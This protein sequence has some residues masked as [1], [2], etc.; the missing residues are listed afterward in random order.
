[1]FRKGL[2]WCAVVLLLVW[3]AGFLL[4]PYVAKPLIVRAL[5]DALQRPVSIRAI[6]FNPIKLVARIE[7][8][9]LGEAAGAEGNF[10]SVEQLS[11][12]LQARSLWERATVID[13]LIITGPQFK[14]VRNQDGSFNFAD[15]LALL[16]KPSSSPPARFVLHNIQLRAGHVALDD[17]LVEARHTVSDIHFSLPFLSNLPGAAQT[18]VEPVL[19]A[20]LN[21]A[22]ISVKAQTTPFHPTR[23]TRAQI[24]AKDVDVPAY[25]RYLPA[26]LNAELASGR[27][28]A[29]LAVSFKQSPEQA[30][31]VG[32]SGVAALHGVS[33]RA[34][35]KTPILSSPHLSL[36]LASADLATRKLVLRAVTLERP[37]L[38][39][40]REKNGSLNLAKL[41]AP[42][43][44]KAGPA[45]AAA[46]AAGAAPA[47][48]VE[49]AQIKLAG[50]LVHFVDKTLAKPFKTRLQQ[51]DLGVTNFSTTPG[52]AASVEASFASDAGE[53]FQHS[54]KVVLAPFSAEGSA[55]LRSLDLTRYRAYY[56]NLV[57]VDL[58]AGKVDLSTR[59]R[60]E[61]GRQPQVLLSG[62]AGKLDA[63][64]LRQRGEK[65]PFLKVGTLSIQGGEFDLAKR[66]VSLE[67]LSTANGMLHAAVNASGQ[68]DL[69]K[70]A[71][72]P[73]GAS[74]AASAKP[75]AA[76][77]PAKAAKVGKETPWQFTLKRLTVEDY[78]ARL[79]SI[80]DGRISTL[81]ADAISLR[82]A[83]LSNRQSSKATLDLRAKLGKTGLLRA[84]GGLVLAP[85]AA[86]LTLDLRGLALVPLQPWFTDQL[87]LTVTDGAVSAKG[88]LALRSK[89]GGGGLLARFVGDAGID[90]LA[91]IDKATSEDL[92]R[93]RSLRLRQVNAATEPAVR[94][95]IA[96][97]AL[98]DFFSRL[99]I[100]RD[101]SFN[102]SEVV[103][104]EEGTTQAGAPSA[105]PVATSVRPRA[106]RSVEMAAAPERAGP[107]AQINIGKV[108]LQDGHV[109]FRDNFI[110]PNYSAQLTG[111]SGSVAGLSSVP[112][113][114]ADIALKGSV[115]NQGQLDITGKVNPLSGNLYLE[116]LAKLTD[117]ELSPLTPYA[118]KYAGYGIEKGKLSFDVKYQV[119]D[120]RLT[121]ENRL[122][123]NRLT[124][125]ERIESPMATKLPVLFAV[126]LLK[127]RNGNIEL[128]LPISG[129]LDDPQFSMGGIIVKAVINLLV[130]VVTAPFSMIAGLFGG[131]DEG[132]HLEFDYGSAALQAAGE[133]KLKSL[134]RALSD[135]P[136][137]KL[138][139]A[140]R[141][142][143]VKDAEGL[144][145]QALLRKVKLQKQ[146]AL[147]RQGESAPTVDAVTLATDEYPKYLAAAYDEEKIPGKPRNLIGMA[148]KLPVAEMEALLLAHITVSEDD[149][150]GLANRRALDVKN[151]LVKSAAVESER[152][153]IVAP[154]VIKAGEDKLRQSRVDFSLGAK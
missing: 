20:K 144:K 109:D 91:T 97:I 99:V 147:V 30:P 11:V 40:T 150:R 32:V 143:P 121:A 62:L 44:Q 10:A 149:L 73:A 84:S 126:A 80:T 35:D 139:V 136:S 19:Q 114:L 29:Q 137:L 122:V 48:A 25:L 90:N 46:S 135:R 1:M 3:A 86:N 81:S 77:K 104:G 61:A 115:D 127:D 100:N 112:G 15:I 129:S 71:A 53:Q 4:L 94:L 59:Y 95:S 18:S 83:N 38:H 142:D 23:E 103:A 39:L 116:L 16:Q 64:S 67:G 120:R 92:L 14:L 106:K 111:L 123:L 9:T 130:R 110:Q 74:S 78:S 65:S 87:N 101:G 82:T 42:A 93:W 133:T 146:K 131:A 12:D 96:E 138:D 145:Q 132:S 34:L 85:L 57:P 21:G 33:L 55:A 75:I 22:P 36:D 107:A 134:A 68:L 52:Q 117:F 152:I 76:I 69:A 26:K 28:D 6:H 24:D 118:A 51:L 119:K 108:L 47:L 140:G 60:F 7:G 63:L 151:Y 105:K 56:E 88:T 125:G 148:K 113:A 79:Q 2:A 54:G 13:E 27:L 49:I 154:R 41:L 70:L 89:P 128:E 50:G 141:T 58:L 31:A 37:E 43:P 17:R 102:F 98:T 8:F 124:F 72:G 45:P 66:S 153:Y 5:T